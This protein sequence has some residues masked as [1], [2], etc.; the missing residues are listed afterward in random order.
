MFEDFLQ[1]QKETIF[2]DLI[3]KWKH[4]RRAFAVIANVSEGYSPI[5]ARKMLEI[6]KK[7]KT[8]ISVSSM[9]KKR[10]LLLFKE[11]IRWARYSI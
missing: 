4:T 2:K 7:I 11:M 5:S 6:G 1:V 10:K 8:D 3:E 9:D